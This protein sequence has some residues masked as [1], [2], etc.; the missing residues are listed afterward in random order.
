MPKI[1]IP[2]IPVISFDDVLPVEILDHV[3]SPLTDKT[4]FKY[5]VYFQAKSLDIL[6]NPIYLI[7]SNRSP[8]NPKLNMFKNRRI[9]TTETALD[10]IKGYDNKRFDNLNREKKMMIST[11]VEYTDISRGYVDF[12]VDLDNF[13]L[14][15]IFAYFTINT[16]ESS[17]ILTMLS[18]DNSKVVERY[19]MPYNDFIFNTQPVGLNYRRI[20]VGT[21]DRKISHF[22]VTSRS[23]YGASQG[24]LDEQDKTLSIRLRNGQGFVDVPE[25]NTVCREYRVSPVSFL[26]K[27]ALSQCK[28]VIVN[29]DQI[30]T[31]KC[32]LYPIEVGSQYAII[33]ATYI[34][35][36][37]V[38]V[39]LL[40]K[41]LTQ[42][43]LEYDSIVVTNKIGFVSSGIR[44]DSLIPYNAYDFKFKFEFKNGRTVIS[45][46]NCVVFPM[47]I[48]D[49]VSL[50]VR[51]TQT[52]FES[53]VVTNTFNVAVDYKNTSQVSRVVNDLK[54]LG[55]E[56]I[57]P[58]E[59]KNLSTQ[60][61]PL[62]SVLVTRTSL[63]TETEERIGLY[64]PGEI[65]V[66]TPDAT[67]CVYQFEVCVRSP[68]DVIE[69]VG[70]SA[71]FTNRNVDDTSNRSMI[72]DKVL[73]INNVVNPK[74]FT[75][76]FF[77]KNSLFK[78]QL[79]YGSSL[80]TSSTGIESGK[81]GVKRI[82]IVKNERIA[83][84]LVIISTSRKK[85]GLFVK[86][87]AQNL[88]DVTKFEIRTSSGDVQLC[89]VDPNVQNY[90]AT[91]KTDSSDAKLLA[92]TNY[93]TIVTTEFSV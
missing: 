24:Q 50:N 35:D 59:I 78:G 70:S 90:A 83:P 4:S 10:A 38:G 75:Q 14:M 68:A 5:R 2:E 22:K 82:V 63:K 80:K 49:V 66:Q 9:T 47:A 89:D 84:T 8:Y 32:I 44:D 28:S 15:T 91:I 77:S 57:F 26:S 13:G 73:S 51:N 69:E 88:D 54:A 17:Q 11:P 56:N 23:L 18:F 12:N 39:T 20:L 55:L 25:V 36:N 65:V 87:S 64:K 48:N 37:V 3:V 40:R 79:A 86:W 19:E 45:E 58:N 52:T 74:N 67:D 29:N 92:Y 42:R 81:T 34:P 72:I 53:N 76:K 93:N 6:R 71:D 33:A 1:V 30:Q 27:T 62:I 31:G 60:I 85:E 16:R 46:S 7:F 21:S 61:D 43:E 41:N